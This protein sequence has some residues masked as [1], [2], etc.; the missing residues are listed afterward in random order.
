MN[1]INSGHIKAAIT[2]LG[3][4]V[5]E[6]VLT[7]ADLEKVLD[8]NDKWIVSRTGIKERRILNDPAKGTSYMAIKAANDLLKKKHFSK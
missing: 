6:E 5:P 2:C 4:Y 3:A 1:Y 8:T 7:N